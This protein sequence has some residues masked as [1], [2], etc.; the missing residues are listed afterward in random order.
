MYSPG[1][2]SFIFPSKTI[3]CLWRSL[4]E[5]QILSVIALFGSFLLYNTTLHLCTSA[6]HVFIIYRCVSDRKIE[7]RK[8]E[9]INSRWQLGIWLPFVQSSSGLSLS[10]NTEKSPLSRTLFHAKEKVKTNRPVYCVYVLLSFWYLRQAWLLS[11][12]SKYHK[13]M[14]YLVL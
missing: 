12:A 14:A 10:W 7:E 9:P 8:R 13:V 3:N 5:G 4:H 2:F 11:S 1:F 6:L